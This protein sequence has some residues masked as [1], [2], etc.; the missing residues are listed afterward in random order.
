M[1]LLK[2]FL[3][4]AGFGLFAG[5]A[6]IIAYDIYL[7][8][9]LRRLL[10]RGA[11][12]A[13]VARPARPTRW[14]VAGKLAGLAWLPLLLSL[15]IVVVPDGRGSVRISQISGVRPGTLYPGV[16]FVLPLVEHVATYNLRDQ[17][18]AT[19]SIEDPKKKAEVLKV[20]SR[21]GLSIGLAVDV[22]YLLGPKQLDHIHAN[23]P[24]PVSEEI[25]VP[26]VATV[27]REVASNYLVREVFATRREE[28]R[29]HAAQ[30]ITARL[31]A[32]GI[33][34]KEVMLR[35]VQLPA[36]YARGLEGLLLKE[37]ENERLG[38]ETEIREKEVRIAELEAEAQKKREVK[39]A[40]ANAQ[41]RVLEAK[42]EADAMQYTLP[43]KEKQIEQSKLEAEARKEATV[44]NAEAAAQAKVIDSKAEVERRKLLAD[45][46]ANRI[47]VTSV[48]DS[49]RMKREALV[50]KQNPLLIQKIIAE[51]LSDKLQIMMVPTDGKFFF[52]NDVMRSAFG[53]NG[54][55]QQDD[56]DDSSDPRPAAAQR[57]QNGRQR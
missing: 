22:R 7:A 8:T 27:F 5:A 40:E 44:K 34:V 49:E 20:Q 43:L 15:S 32:D 46:E 57:G 56:P 38:T 37:Q 52:A 29:Q 45:A 21:E 14:N 30:A 19:S 42:S 26:V 36:E 53:G 17:V 25:V 12:P 28:L 31:G 3:L 48:A 39:R 9:Q 24:Q 51:R 18:F 1:L 55:Q 6:T 10:A 13:A 11:E 33:L 4:A 54:A 35:D 41:V 50:L 2:Y 16:H 47:R 23:L